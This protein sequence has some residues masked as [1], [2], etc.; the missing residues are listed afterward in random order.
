MS[1]IKNGF[2]EVEAINEWCGHPFD[3]SWH[4]NSKGIIFGEK[5]DIMIDY[6]E[7]KKTAWNVLAMGQ[8]WLMVIVEISHE[9]VCPLPLWNFL[10]LTNHFQ[11]CVWHLHRLENLNK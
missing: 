6:Q 1:G 3:Y 8:D 7:A 5:N 4:R 10:Y 2:V 11:N 9:L